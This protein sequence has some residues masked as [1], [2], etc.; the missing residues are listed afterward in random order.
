MYVLYENYSPQLTHSDKGDEMQMELK[1]K[2]K[3]YKYTYQEKEIR[4]EYFTLK[5]GVLNAFRGIHFY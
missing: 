1:R 5:N 2:E 3:I 4:S